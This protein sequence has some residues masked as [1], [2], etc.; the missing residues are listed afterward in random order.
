MARHREI[1]RMGVIGAIGAPAGRSWPAGATVA[2]AAR[3]GIRERPR[4]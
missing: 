4:S 1:R 2:K 3:A